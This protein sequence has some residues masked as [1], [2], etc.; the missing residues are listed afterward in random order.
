LDSRVPNK[1][2]CFGTE[3]NQQDQAELLSFLDKNSDMLVWSTSDLVRVNRYVIEHQLQVSPNAK[4][5]NQ[6]LHKMAE[7][8]VQAAKADVQRLLDAGFIREVVYAQC[9]SNVVMV[10]KKNE[11]WQMCTDFMN[12]NKCCP[13]DDFPLLRLDKIIDS[14]VASEMMALLDCFSGYHQI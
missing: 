5:K 13:K 2:V 9:L 10:K 3:A 8:K 1:T 14:V 4:P 6:K 7:E 12:L 11:K